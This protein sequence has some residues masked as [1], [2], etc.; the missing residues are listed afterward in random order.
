MSYASRLLAMTR[1]R[2]PA[3]G[4]RVVGDA[5]G[6]TEESVETSASAPPPKT[7]RADDVAAPSARR[8]ATA[9]VAPA[10]ERDR[11]ERV[12]EHSPRIE[13]TV[14]RTVERH[15]VTTAAATPIAAPEPPPTIVFPAQTEWLVDDSRGPDPLVETAD[16]DALRDL[17]RTVRQWTSSPPTV[18]DS[19]TESAPPPGPTDVVVQP[20]ANQISIG[21]VTITVDDLPSRPERAGSPARSTA[22]R[23]AR[24]LVREPR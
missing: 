12:V 17:M 11:A 20:P 8:A 10:M 6:V 15:T 23:M 19:H 2:V 13:R 3:I 9:P 18:I 14:E 7:A 5:D 4:P 21:N 16:S 22:D 24:H 1:G